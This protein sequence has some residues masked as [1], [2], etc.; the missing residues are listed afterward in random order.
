MTIKSPLKS[1]NGINDTKV[2]NL[3]FEIVNL[4]VKLAYPPH[5]QQTM[6]NLKTLAFLITNT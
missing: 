5:Y 3:M 2:Y 1:I 6:S 4:I